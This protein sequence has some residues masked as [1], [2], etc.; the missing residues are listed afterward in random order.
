MIARATTGQGI[1]SEP[2][3]EKLGIEAND[4]IATSNEM[5]PRIPPNLGR[6]RLVRII[7]QAAWGW[8]M[9][10]NKITLGVP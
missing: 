2:I 4:S 3:W 7:E 1:L 5:Q 9:R 8:S 10:R 6:Y